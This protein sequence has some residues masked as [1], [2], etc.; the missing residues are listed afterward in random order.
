MDTIKY[1]LNGAALTLQ[2]AALPK[3]LDGTYAKIFENSEHKGALK[4]LLQWLAFSAS[5]LTV[6]SLAEVLAVDFSGSDHPVYKPDLR[7]KRPADILRIC[8]GLVTEF[9][10]EIHSSLTMNVALTETRD[11]KACTFF[12]QGIF[13][14]KYCH[15]AAFTLC[16]H[17]NLPSANFIFRST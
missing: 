12:R 16:H 15:R 6:E 10:G 9:K 11:D 13:L 14:P 8:Y 4:I 2:L 1:C 7:C 17:S 3:G 5:P